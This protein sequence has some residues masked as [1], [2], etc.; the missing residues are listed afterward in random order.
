MLR[1]GGCYLEVGSIAPGNVFSYDAT[2][3]VRGNARLVATSNYS[4]GR[5]SSRWSS[6]AATSSGSVR[7]GGLPRVSR[8]SA[9]RTRFSRPTGVSARAGLATSPRRDLDVSSLALV[10]LLAWAILSPGRRRRRLIRSP[11]GPVGSS[12][13][14]GPLHARPPVAGSRG[15]RGHDH[16]IPDALRRPRRAAQAR[17]LG[18][19]DA[20][21]RRVVVALARRLVYDFVLRSGVKFHNGDTLTAE[22]VKFSSSAIAAPTRSS[23]RTR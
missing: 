6:C 16:A 11:S 7:A 3:L 4:P 20:L 23:S 1:G 9:S 21:P 5:S 12:N 10:V 15:E 19:G 18:R 2:T 13:L 22:D 14:G 17:C 8:S